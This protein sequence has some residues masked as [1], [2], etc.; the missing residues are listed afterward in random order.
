MAGTISRPQQIFQDSRK[1][2]KM[3]LTQPSEN[4][5]RT[6]I[7]QHFSL[8]S[9]QLSLF[10]NVRSKIARQLNNDQLW[11]T[12]LLT[13]N[14]RSHIVRRH[15][16]SENLP[17]TLTAARCVTGMQLMRS[18]LAWL[19]GPS[20]CLNEWSQLYRFVSFGLYL[21]DVKITT[22]NF[23]RHDSSRPS[24]GAKVAPLK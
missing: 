10:F 12:M 6:K 20:G 17:V 22:V 23:D 3:Y 9:Q 13:T 4:I 7:T 11:N 18:R 19:P 15:E 1:Y 14:R 16:S 24:F 5:F 2:S 8:S 21:V